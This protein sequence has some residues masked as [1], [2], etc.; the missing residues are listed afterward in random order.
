MVPFPQP[1]TASSLPV[2]ADEKCHQ[3]P[4]RACARERQ[5][6]LVVWLCFQSQI[7]IYSGDAAERENTPACSNSTLTFHIPLSGIFGDESV[8]FSNPPTGLC[9]WE[10]QSVPLTVHHSLNYHL[11]FYP[12]PRVQSEQNK[13]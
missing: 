9:C 5:G 8:Y 3:S 1:E 4:P 11:R 10:L 2:R 12:S 7:N 13:A 6:K